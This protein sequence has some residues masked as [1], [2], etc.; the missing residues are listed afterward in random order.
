MHIALVNRWYPPETGGGGVATHNENFARACVRL[1]HQVTVIAHQ[2]KS[3]V[4]SPVKRN[5]I[6]IIRIPIPDTSRFNRIP[7]I[8]SQYRFLQGFL[9]SWRVCQALRFVHKQTPV[10]VAEFAEVNAEALFWTSNDSRRLVVR[11]HTP[12]YILRKYYTVAEMR[13]ATSLIGWAERRT[14]R[15]AHGRTAPS[16]DMAQVISKSC[17]L[18]PDTIEVIPNAVDDLPESAPTYSTSPNR[19]INVLFVGRFERVKG[20]DLILECIP[21]ICRSA[22]NIRFTLV[23]SDLPR[24][25]NQTYKQFISATLSDY[26]DAGRLDVKGFVS[27]DEIKELYQNADMCLVPSLLYESFSMTCVQAMAYGKPVIASSIG[28]IPDTLGNTGII[29]DNAD[30]E[31]LTAAILKLAGDPAQRYVLGKAAYK[32]VL[33]NF[34][35]D[36]VTTRTIEYY[37]SLL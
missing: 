16:R 9:Y 36:I 33:E 8:G 32:R 26:I 31:H 24:T 3:P 13:F 18:V 21:H 19:P 15:Q 34:T 11:C 28:G 37:Q 6:T 35:S 5:G 2:P 12:T 22:S 14:I 4:A 29:L 10:D 23:G 20:I 30:Q 1:G 25:R 27:D 17:S 7:M